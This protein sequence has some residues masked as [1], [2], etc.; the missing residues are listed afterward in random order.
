MVDN[1]A[2]SKSKSIDDMTSIDYAHLRRLDLNLLLAPRRS[3][4]RYGVITREET[5]LERKF[6][7]SIA[8]TARGCGADCRASWPKLRDQGTRTSPFPLRETA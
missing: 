1:G 4:I 7:K 8:A 2:T 3:N 6:W 5:Y